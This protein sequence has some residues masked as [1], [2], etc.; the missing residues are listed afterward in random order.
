MQYDSAGVDGPR[1][2]INSKP[3]NLERKDYILRIIEEFAR[4]IA[5]VVLLKETKSY[6]DAKMELDALTLSITGLGLSHIK[7]LG[8]EGVA[9]VFSADKRSEAEKIYC[10][11]RILKEDSLVLESEGNTEESLKS[12]SLSEELFKL[13]SDKKFDF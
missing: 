3:A 12:L 5:R 6:T 11:A 10:M 4:V 13:V 2:I 1:H 9:Y 7:S 8:P